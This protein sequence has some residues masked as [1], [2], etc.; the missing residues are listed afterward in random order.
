MMRVMLYRVDHQ[1]PDRWQAAVVLLAEKRCGALQ[2][3]C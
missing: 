2:T 3:P 1:P